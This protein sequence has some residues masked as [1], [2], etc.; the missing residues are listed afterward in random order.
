M[1]IQWKKRWLLIWSR[2]Q[3]RGNG[4]ETALGIMLGDNGRGHLLT[5]LEEWLGIELIE[6]ERQAIPGIKPLSRNNVEECKT[7]KGKPK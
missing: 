6:T 7:D 5:G 3:W 2:S 4:E 1:E